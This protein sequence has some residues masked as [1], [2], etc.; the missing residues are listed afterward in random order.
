MVTVP[1]NSAAV[2]S[3]QRFGGLCQCKSRFSASEVWL[4][5]KHFTYHHSKSR[6][7]SWADSAYPTRRRP[8][9]ITVASAP[10]SKWFRCSKDTSLEKLSKEDKDDPVS[11]EEAVKEVA[12]ALQDPD[13]DA[14]AES[15][16]KDLG[17]GEARHKNGAAATVHETNGATSAGNKQQAASPGDRQGV[18]PTENV[19]DAAASSRVGSRDISPTSSVDKGWEGTEQDPNWDGGQPQKGDPLG[20]AL[21][22]AALVGMLW[23][24]STIFRLAGRLKRRYLH[25]SEGRGMAPPV[26]SSSLPSRKGV[27]D[28][29][30]PDD[31]I[32]DVEEP[33]VQEEKKTD[34][35]ASSAALKMPH[36]KDL[37]TEDLFNND[38]GSGPAENSEEGAALKEGALSTSGQ[39][40]G[41]RHGPQPVP[42]HQSRMQGVEPLH[43]ADT[44]RVGGTLQN[45]GASLSLTM[46]ERGS[47]DD[48]GE[49]AERPGPLSV[50]HDDARGGPVMG[51]A[52]QQGGSDHFN[53]EL[54]STSGP[55]HFQAGKPAGGKH[56]A[57]VGAS[58]TG[59]ED[60]PRGVWQYPT[61]GIAE[62]EE[63]SGTSH[64]SGWPSWASFG[65]DEV[66]PQVS[67]P[68]LPDVRDRVFS[69]HS[70]DPA[71][72]QLPSD[73]SLPSIRH[74]AAV[75]RRAA[76]AASDASQRASAYSAAAASAASKAA[77]H[78]ERA[79][80]AA[81]R[82]QSALE[83]RS[84]EAVSEAQAR[85]E[86][87]LQA[88]REAEE[89]TAGAAALATAHQEVSASQA[90]LAERAAEV[91]TPE[92]LR[93]GPLTS[94]RT[95]AN[96]A[97][98]AV[99][100]AAGSAGRA[101]L[102]WIS[103]VGL[104][105][106]SVRLWLWHGLIHIWQSARDALGS[107]WK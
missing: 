21:M 38:D 28:V 89:R 31:H 44:E 40:S 102:S 69:E 58:E 22:I 78:A 43:F 37:T 49:T 74:R 59:R 93:T 29:Y 25:S 85:V 90:A 51:E 66:L 53:V 48:V 105:L 1:M 36:D 11:A 41:P 65:Q 47:T 60:G 13:A 70:V 39:A 76:M 33:V 45:G 8:S 9:D 54:P 101:I 86:A 14:A 10:W 83:K 73:S 82:A 64:Q 79:S 20:Y 30:H 3:R 34:A 107:V 17:P 95:W 103:N 80:E 24:T 35:P 67:V 104:W 32:L 6:K 81:T 75:A 100:D 68:P 5:R 7:L 61:S 72:V 12:Q 63:E 16:V 57:D 46:D 27:N 96:G 26:H 97:R 15:T 42:G 19:L 56:P 50:Q 88:A 2:R 99:Q 18:S 77:E 71:S 23:L 84:E 92:T 91:P 4:I 55:F 52:G 87:A 106:D 98:F 62:Q 94:M